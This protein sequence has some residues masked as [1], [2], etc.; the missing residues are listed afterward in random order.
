MLENNR[1]T[2]GEKQNQRSMPIYLILSVR[3]STSPAAR[4]KTGGTD[5]QSD[6]Q[7]SGEEDAWPV[8]SQATH[9]CFFSVLVDMRQSVRSSK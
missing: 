9:T 1:N 4:N 7:Q 8:H 2:L 6:A 5:H 3:I